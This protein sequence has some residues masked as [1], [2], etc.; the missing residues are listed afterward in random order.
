VSSILDNQ[1][2]EIKQKTIS[3]NNPL[4]YKNVDFY[5]S[6]WN[7]IGIRIKKISEN[8]IYEF[9]LFKLNS[10][11]KSWIT[12]INNKEKSYALVFDS[13]DNNFLLYDETGVLIGNK[14]LNDKIR[15]EEVV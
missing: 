5:Q 13:F 15:S 11:N 14:N 1:G 10:N 3:V 9:P 12:W 2:K 4:R 6:D 7:L 8:K